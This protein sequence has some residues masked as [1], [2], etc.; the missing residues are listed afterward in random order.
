MGYKCAPQVMGLTRNEPK[1]NAKHRANGKSILQ[2]LGNERYSRS[3]T[4]DRT[5]SHLNE[6]AGFRSGKECWEHMCNEADSYRIEG[7]TKDGVKFS[8]ALRKDAVIGYALIINPPADMT[9]GWSEADYANFYSDSFEVLTQIQPSVFNYNNNQMYAIHRDEGLPNDD[10]TYSEHCHFVGMA[11]DGDGKFC[12]NLI[13]AKLCIEINK[14]FPKLMRQRGYDL[15]DLD[16]TDWQRLKSDEEYRTA[17]KAKRKEQKSG[18]SVNRYIQEKAKKTN[19]A[20]VQ[21]NQLMTDLQ[22][23][24]DGL[25]EYEDKTITAANQRAIEIRKQ[26]KEDAKTIKTQAKEDA[27]TIKEQAKKDAEKDAK[28]IIDDAKEKAKSAAYTELDALMQQLND[29]IDEGK[30][31]QSGDEL[32]EFVFHLA[33]EKKLPAHDGRSLYDVIEE[34]RQKKLAT[35][36]DFRKR[37]AAVMEHAEEIQQQHKEEQERRL[38]KGIDFH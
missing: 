16:T 35:R 2:E 23:A 17:R 22:K 15:D 33:K 36:E 24:Q 27:K 30:A 32:D 10:G 11:R 25:D 20:L 1:P 21:A 5:R 29:L 4:L 9:V 34:Q 19:E 38:P 3:D 37:T 6:Y 8:K 31:E 13:D 7:T 14:Q 28:K 26:A 12:G 18:L